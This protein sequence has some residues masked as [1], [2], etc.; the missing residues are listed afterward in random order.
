MKKITLLLI[1]AIVSI[2]PLQSQT[3][4]E[5]TVLASGGQAS[6]AGNLAHIAVIGETAIALNQ[7]NQHN[8]G[9]LF[10]LGN[11]QLTG[12]DIA[13][14]LEGAWDQSGNMHT[15]LHT[16]GLIPHTQPYNTEPWNYAG[17]ESAGVIPAG[18]VDWILVELR[19]AP[20]AAQ[21]I[22]A[23]IVEGWPKALFLRNDGSVSDTNGNVPTYTFSEISDSLFV[24]IRHRNHLAVM[25]S[26]GLTL[27][28]N[29]YSYDFTDG[30]TKAFGGEDGYKQLEEGIFG[31]AGGDADADG[32]VF[33]SDRTL[34]R[35]ELGT[36]SA[37]HSTDFDMDGNIFMSDRTLWRS[38]LGT[39]NPITGFF[40]KPRF[41]SQVPK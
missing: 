4:H 41:I 10:R 31:M 34:W 32:N 3:A 2:R 13:L 27:T 6:A 11:L 1:L 22:P 7:N 37:Y 23:T 19:D 5:S 39:S 18:V 24:V 20:T 17:N 14:F 38:N 16:A 9:F 33:M 40:I 12:L 35:G 29:T 28:G 8:A 30:I 36:T 21:A 15:G 26:H 25:S